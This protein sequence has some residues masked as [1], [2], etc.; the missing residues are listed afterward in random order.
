LQTSGFRRVTGLSAWF[1][2]FGAML[3]GALIGIAVPNAHAAGGESYDYDGLGRLVR[4]ISSSGLVTEYVYDAAGNITAV[5]RGAAASPPALSAV[6][7]TSIRRGSQVRVTL[8]GSELQNVALQAL[9]RELTI[10][11]V[12]R[13]ATSLAFDLAASAQAALGASI[14]RVSS[15]A[16]SATINL[17]VRPPLPKIELSPLPIAVPP[18]GRSAAIDL[19]LSNADDQAHIIALST[20]RPDLASVSPAS[21]T[22]PAGSTRTTIFVTGRAGGN[23]ELK[24]DSAT[25]GNST[26][27]VF[28][29]AAFEGINTA[30]AN[31]VGVT[32]AAPAQPPAV[33][34][35]LLAVPVGVVRGD[36]AWFDTAPRFVSQ[37]GTQTL[38]ITG[39][40]LPLTLAITVEPAD[41]LSVGVP[42]VAADGRSATVA[43]SATASAAQGLRRLVLRSGASALTPVAVGAD[44]FDVV[45]PL[46]ELVSIQPLLV[47]PGS[48]VPVFEL[49]GRNL[50]DVTAVQVLGGGVSVGS[51]LVS[52]AEG[53]LLQVALQVSPAAQPGPRTVVVFAP[54]GSSSTLASLANTLT[55]A[56]DGAGL[57]PYADLAA[58]VVGVTKGSASPPAALLA[59]VDAPAVGVATGPMAVSSTPATIARTESVSLVIQGQF[60]AGAT[61]VTITPNTGLTLGLPSLSADGKQLTVSVSAAADAPLGAR[62][63]DVLAGGQPL[64]V[65]G[66]GALAL[67]VTLLTP[68]VESI[69][70]NS[71]IPS[72]AAF[73]FT[74]RGRN[75]LGATAVRVSPAADVTVGALSV[76]TAGTEI[77]LQLTVAAN[78]VRGVRTVTVVTPAGESSSAPGPNN[79]L[80]LSDGPALRDLSAAPVGVV[81]G[82]VV[83]VNPDALIA[84]P[85]VGVAV[86]SLASSTSNTVIAPNVGVAL[87]NLAA[88]GRTDTALAPLVGVVLG[89]SPDPNASAIDVAALPTGVARG[90]LA[91][92]VEPAA[93]VPGQ[94]GTL[95]VNG[96]ALPPGTTVQVLP[97]GAATLNGAASVDAGGGAVRQGLTVNA[98]TPLPALEVA[99]VKPDGTLVPA[100][101]TQ[102]RTLVLLPG[103]PEIVSLNPILA[104]QGDSG[105]LVVRGNR[106]RGAARVAAE[107]GAGIEFASEF[108]VNAAG[109]EL[110]IR[111]QVRDDAPLGARV[112]RVFN[113]LGGSAAAAA[114]ANTFTVFPKD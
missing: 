107:P 58:P 114:P 8:T 33:V 3:L 92:L 31:L 93:W 57:Q 61:A 54:G 101:G 102:A 52:N 38:Q 1:A 91:L 89:T 53:T 109:T 9:D 32:L 7:P 26:F 10:S 47:V 25:L 22:I 51:S 23:T 96:F 2:F 19:L 74:I 71:T 6:A 87:G 78:A 15:A 104:R 13:T 108:S 77:R 16:G 103:T 113:L 29:L 88:P 65:A 20:V 100:A 81:L 70:P 12:T 76:N 40:G 17:N 24:L 95:V 49:R 75:L 64:R 59:V 73:D 5:I 72:G 45:A 44:V 66:S 42:S 28:V 35:G 86:G 39:A 27:P 55:V 106:L 111:Y 90:P 41:G 46:P 99:L 84:A 4:V 62:R 80:R 98:A 105:T 94:T 43:V 79:Q 18:D 11:S 85:V 112:I 50:Q 30:R 63:I 67:Q 60:L 37:G 48:T 83:P 110:Q 36:T 69:T 82:T 34:S 21:V 97:A 56:P 14:L 68:V